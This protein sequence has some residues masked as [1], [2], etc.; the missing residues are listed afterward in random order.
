MRQ[1]LVKNSWGLLDQQMVK[2]SL[3]TL[4]NWN[5]YSVIS[6]HQVL[7]IH[8]VSKITAALKDDQTDLIAF[9]Q[10]LLVSWDWN[11]ERTSPNTISV[12]WKIQ[13]LILFV[14]IY[15]LL[16]QQTKISLYYLIFTEQLQDH[17]ASLFTIL[18]FLQSKATVWLFAKIHTLL[19]FIETVE[20]AGDLSGH[21]ILFFITIRMT[22]RFW[23]NGT[24]ID[25]FI[26]DQLHFQIWSW[27]FLHYLIKDSQP[28]YSQS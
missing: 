9:Q 11:I 20:T 3:A 22:H 18:P 15:F 28:A 13:Q 7:M 16:T 6:I 8:T 27:P 24:F 2:K 12:S 10:C 21:F 25:Q 4:K 17:Q 1:Q 19:F 23:S 5:A 14:R 26:I